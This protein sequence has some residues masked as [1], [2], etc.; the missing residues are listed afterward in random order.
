MNGSTA[1]DPASHEWAISDRV[2]Q[3]R[4]WGTAVVFPL[5]PGVDVLTLGSGSDCS[6]RVDDPS[7][8]VSRTHARLE[9]TATGWGVI[10]LGSKNGLQIDGA[11]RS[12]GTLEPGT[13]LALGG[14][15]LIAESEQL[16]ALRG[17]LER[18]LGWG[19]ARIP[20]VDRA[21]RFVR[22]AA[23]H[24]TRLVLSG[25]GELTMIA[26]SLHTR[27]LGRNRPFILC[28]PRRAESD[29]NVRSV[30]NRDDVRVAMRAAVGGSLCFLRRRMPPDALDA[31]NE[32]DG[33]KA[34][35][36]LIVCTHEQEQHPGESFL[37]TRIVI[38]SLAERVDEVSRIIAEYVNDAADEL[39]VRPSVLS[40]ADREWVRKF[41]ASS[42]ADVE[43]GT[44]RL[45]A[46]RASRTISLAAAR[47][48]MAPVSLT[49]WIGRR[50]LPAVD[51]SAALRGASR[52]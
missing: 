19:E 29:G 37:A 43:K 45:V 31:F 27:V 16:I 33:P 2:I 24:R 30:A 1:T 12:M 46:L 5:R 21:L 17:F 25:K 6:L 10:D 3:L 32:L 35:V 14:V 7:E 20:D 41:S 13:E 23:T 15:V 18:L 9:R 47:L 4:Q 52:P 36:Q 48:E 28:D 11:R 50:Q 44:R 26:Q 8:Q 42:L 22:M 34:R 40:D 49:R 39:K 38:P 51:V